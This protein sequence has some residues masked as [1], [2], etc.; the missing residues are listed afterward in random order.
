MLQG[1]LPR[2]FL[3][4]LFTEDLNIFLL[5]KLKEQIVENRDWLLEQTN[6]RSEEHKRP[7]RRWYSDIFGMEGF[8]IDK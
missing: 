4:D 2:A 3:T 1:S 6:Y 7:V 8:T 5:D